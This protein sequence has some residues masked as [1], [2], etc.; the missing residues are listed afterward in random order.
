MVNDQETKETIKIDEWVM[1]HQ[2]S[3]KTIRNQVPLNTL[4]KV[5]LG[6]D[7]NTD[8]LAQ[9]HIIPGTSAYIVY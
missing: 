5:T 8:E 6:R 4:V 7:F 3:D 9:K 1:Q 2:I